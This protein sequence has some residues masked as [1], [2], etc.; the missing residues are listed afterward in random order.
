[1]E[2]RKVGYIRASSKDQIEGR[3]MESIKNQGLNERDI[4]IDK[5]RGYFIYPFI[6]SV[7]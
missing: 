3:Q 5:K 2:V 6:R 4:I 7:W 1:M